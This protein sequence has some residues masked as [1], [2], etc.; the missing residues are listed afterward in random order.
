LPESG[1]G[2]APGSAGPGTARSH[3]TRLGPTQSERAV[4]VRALGAAGPVIALGA[5]VGWLAGA[6]GMAVWL[7]GE[8]WW[9]RRRKRLV[10]DVFRRAR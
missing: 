4:V 9:L 6:L 7:A 5:V 1:F 10:G 8:A 2:F 3:L